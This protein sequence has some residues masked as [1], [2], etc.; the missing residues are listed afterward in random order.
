MIKNYLKSYG[1][2][3][4]LIFIMILF[5]SILN[6]F[7]PFKTNIIK[8][9]IPIISMFISSIILGK[10]TQEKAYLE[11]LK[12]SIL[13]ILF[14]TILKIIIKT[15]FNYKVFIIFIA[16]IISSVFGSMIGINLK[17]NS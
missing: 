9:V 16:Q 7:I 15:D 12:F 8:V 5:I 3:F 10:N 17:K 6:Y 11:G 1:Y 2:L 13:F 4:G 14:I